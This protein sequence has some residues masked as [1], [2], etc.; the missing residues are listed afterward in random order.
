MSS[1]GEGFIVACLSEAFF[2]W[3]GHLKGLSELQL[4]NAIG[5]W[6]DE[7]FAI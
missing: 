6:T 5:A 3:T 4:V 1:F 2:Y 7:W